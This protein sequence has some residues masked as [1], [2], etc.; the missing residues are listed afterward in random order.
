MLT[1]DS[2]YSFVTFIFITLFKFIQPLN[3]SSPSV[4]SRGRLSPVRALVSRLDLPSIINPSNGIFSP[5][6]TVIISPI[7]ISS[8][9]TFSNLPFLST[10]AKSG[11]I[12]IKLEID[13]LDLSTA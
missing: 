10:F 9:S 11:L 5:G 13:F 3:T 1:V 7:F 4:T 8:G 12:S 6:L 2:P